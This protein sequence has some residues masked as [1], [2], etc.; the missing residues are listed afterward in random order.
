[1]RVLALP[2][3]AHRLDQRHCL[4]FRTIQAVEDSHGP[5]GTGVKF[6]SA[7]MSESKCVQLVQ[8]TTISSTIVGA[9]ARQCRPSQR[10]RTGASDRDVRNAG[11]RRSNRRRPSRGGRPSSPGVA[12]RVER[13]GWNAGKPRSL[14][15]GLSRGKVAQ[16][17]GSLLGRRSPD[18]VADLTREFDV[19]TDDGRG[20]TVPV[21]VAVRT[22]PD[23]TSGHSIPPLR[24]FQRRHD[25]PR[26]SSACEEPAYR[27]AG[28]YSAPGERSL[29]YQTGQERDFSVNR[30]AAC[31]AGPQGAEPAPGRRP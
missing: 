26:R 22:S 20:P 5:P 15:S 10:E 19:P 21:L 3:F 24:A 14:A 18:G 31:G 23:V 1:M 8:R 16:H 29:R 17:R 28:G 25:C 7:A 12:S 9:L 13:R 2:C 6:R 11:H 30:T 4:A 27:P